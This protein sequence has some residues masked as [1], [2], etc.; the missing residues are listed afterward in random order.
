MYSILRYG[1]LLLF[2][3]LLLSQHVPKRRFKPNPH[4]TSDTFRYEV[5]G[6][7]Y[8]FV[9]YHGKP[10]KRP[11][12]KDW[13]YHNPANALTSPRA[14][15]AFAKKEGLLDFDSQEQWVH[16]LPYYQPTHPVTG[17]EYNTFVKYVRDS[18][19]HYHLGEKLGATYSSPGGA[20]RINW[21]SAS[22]LR[23]YRDYYVDLYYDRKSLTPGKLD[24][25]YF[26]YQYSYN[27]LIHEFNLASRTP[28]VQENMSHRHSRKH[29]LSNR[30]LVR[31]YPDTFLWTNDSCLGIDSAVAKALA[32]GNWISSKDNDQV[33]AFVTPSQG[34]AHINWVAQHLVANQRQASGIMTNGTYIPMAKDYSFKAGADELAHCRITIRAYQE[35]LL[36][37][38]DSIIRTELG[39]PYRMW[40]TNNLG[41]SRINWEEPLRALKTAE[42]QQV[43][44]PYCKT[45]DNK[46]YLEP[47]ILRFTYNSTR[48]KEAEKA[49]QKANSTQAFFAN[50]RIDHF[51]QRHEVFVYP[52]SDTYRELLSL[53]HLKPLNSL[54]KDLPIKGI[55]YEQALAYWHWRLYEKLKSSPK[56]ISDFY[57][58]TRSEWQGIQ[59]GEAIQ[60]V[61]VLLPTRFNS[62]SYRIYVGTS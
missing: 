36:Y 5:E 39:A 52:A 32:D 16:I 51:I 59:K 15:L 27:F 28:Y 25:K 34:K 17:A 44:H 40:I 46:P 18:V 43:L 54:K 13:V 31:V 57:I 21:L 14:M 11:P 47:R 50:R 53:D 33:P 7:V 61:Q 4:F 9:T 55:S 62:F 58:P 49:Y 60:P 20:T 23:Q 41:T 30:G 56:S 48:Q 12:F 42:A 26:V 29:L 45:I 10:F 6:Q 19:I 37:C 1:M 22:E 3:F 24:P 2:P 38:R 35:F 8:N